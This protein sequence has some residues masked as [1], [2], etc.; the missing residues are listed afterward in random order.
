MSDK[1]EQ[2]NEKELE[3]VSGGSWADVV[4]WFKKKYEEIQKRKQTFK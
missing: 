3:N 2:L 1:K 4:E